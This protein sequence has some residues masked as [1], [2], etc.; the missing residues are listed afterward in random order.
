[1]SLDS[2]DPQ[3]LVGSIGW[4]LFVFILVVIL[5]LFFCLV[6]ALTKYKW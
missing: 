1:M 5:S 2:P 4:G 6:G 3:Y